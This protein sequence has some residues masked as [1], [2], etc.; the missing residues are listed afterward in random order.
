MFSSVKFSSRV[1]LLSGAFRGGLKLK[2]T[3]DWLA[4]L[5]C[6][7]QSTGVDDSFTDQLVS[8]NWSPS[9]S[10]TTPKATVE[11]L[12]ALRLNSCYELLKIGAVLGGAKLFSTIVMSNGWR[13][14]LKFYL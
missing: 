10:V 6:R 11:K 5:F 7:I 1:N 3:S 9:I 8:E 13:I 4:G 2:I 12:P 14:T